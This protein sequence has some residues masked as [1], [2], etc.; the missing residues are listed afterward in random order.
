MFLVLVA[1]SVSGILTYLLT[2]M[3]LPNFVAEVDSFHQGKKTVGARNNKH[4]C[5]FH[6]CVTVMVSVHDVS[7]ASM[8]ADHVR[9]GLPSWSASYG[10]TT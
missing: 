1:G 4:I 9:R 5:H 10:Y 6:S 7:P 2:F 3:D 8:R